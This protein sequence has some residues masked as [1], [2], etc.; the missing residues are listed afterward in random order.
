M[1]KYP[2]MIKGIKVRILGDAGPFSKMG[3]SI[4][5]SVTIG[6]SHYLID[7]GAALFQQIGGHGLKD[8]QGLIITHCHDDH[9]RWFTDMAIFYRYA[10]D[11]TGSIPLFASE[12]VRN[13]LCS[14]SK[15]ALDRTLSDDSRR[16]VDIRCGDYIDYNTLG[17]EARY[18]IIEKDEDEGRYRLCITDEEGREVGSDRARIVISELSGR[19]RMLF[20]DPDYNEWVEPESFY[21]FSSDIFYKSDKNIFRDPEGFTIE[22][23]KA[24]VWHGIPNIGI[25][26]RTLDETLVFSSDTVHDTVLWKDLC[27]IARSPIHNPEKG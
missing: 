5:Y 11:I 18:K 8:L 6:R 1:L 25:R 24:P 14:M 16:I 15:P 26:F 9:K 3:K 22:A 19:A 7:C 12:D 27:D 13:E 10:R 2:S 20:K 23:L 21:S 4:G 17:P